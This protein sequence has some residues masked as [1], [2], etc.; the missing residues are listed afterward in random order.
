MF[1]RVLRASSGCCDSS[2]L[3]QRY[4]DCE[5]FLTRC[6]RAS[7]TRTA[8]HAVVQLHPLCSVRQTKSVADRAAHEL[9]DATQ[10]ASHM[11]PHTPASPAV[12]SRPLEIATD[13]DA[14]PDERGEL[15]MCSFYMRFR[16]HNVETPRE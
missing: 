13:S 2:R 12:T 3:E 14:A 10:G 15:M 1:F 7:T 5:A 16:K 4:D 9:L 6:W 8:A 11:R